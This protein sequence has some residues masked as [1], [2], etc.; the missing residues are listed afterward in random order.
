LI[1]K[2]S[3]LIDYGQADIWVGHRHMNNV[4]TGNLIPER[5]VQRIRGLDGV[6]RADPYIVMFSGFQTP[7]GHWEGVVV[8]GCDPSSLLGNAW[9]MSDG[10]PRAI[11]HPDGVLVDVYDVEKLGNPQIGDVREIGNHRAKIVG[12]TRGIVSFTT[13]PYVF[14]TLE[15]ARKKYLVGV[16]PDQCSY[17]LVKARPGTDT[18]DLVRRIQARVPELDVYDRQTY[19]TKS[20]V[21]WLTRTGIGISFGLAA[22]LG[23]LVGL[24]VV[25]QTLYSSVTV[26]VKEFGTLKAMGADDRCIGRFLVA[27]ALGNAVLGSV[28]GLAAS[29][30][31]GQAMS[32]ARA[33]VIL[34]GWV[35]VASVALVGMVC[36]AAAWLPYWRIRRI[37]P[38]SVLRS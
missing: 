9:V 10:D 23:L 4:D 31:L 22:L 21:Y 5:W 3:L 2:A 25:A 6:E 7:D 16:R 37:D 19:A 33:P 36:L 13:S 17:F 29:V 18:A 20:M 24:A 15:R 34:T 12:M 1:Q 27:Q 14:T 8:V 38:A 30:G 26:R 28:V 35:A 32:T 11:R